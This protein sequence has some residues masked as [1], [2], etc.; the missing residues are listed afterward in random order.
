MHIECLINVLI[1]FQNTY[2]MTDVDQAGDEAAA[3][4]V[5]EDPQDGAGASDVSGDGPA[6]TSG[7]TSDQLLGYFRDKFVRDRERFIIARMGEHG[8]KQKLMLMRSPLWRRGER[9]ERDQ[10]M[11]S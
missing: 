9:K 6:D 7:Q 3:A 5:E 2:S 10:I 4:A 1:C 11:K 8:R